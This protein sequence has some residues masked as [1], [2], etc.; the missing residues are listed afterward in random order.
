[1]KNSDL[2]FTLFYLL[3]SD[4]DGAK[5]RLGVPPSVAE[6]QN[7]VYKDWASYEKY[8]H[9][10]NEEALCYVGEKAKDRCFIGVL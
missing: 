8:V 2:L 9:K 7:Q 1:M 5:S 6:S 3:F 4:N 10:H